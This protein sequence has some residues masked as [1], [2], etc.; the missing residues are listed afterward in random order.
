M[1]A[2]AV[3]ALSGLAAGA[4]ALLLPKKAGATSSPPGTGVPAPPG[5]EPPSTSPP[6]TAT[7]DRV[8][9]LQSPYVSG[10]DVAEL[11][12]RLSAWGFE[13]GTIDGVFGPKTDA[14]VRS[15]QRVA[16]LDADGI[17]GPLTW[18]A[19][20]SEPPPVDSGV[21]G[22]P[23][24]P[25]A[26][27]PAP[28]PSPVPQPVP[29]ESLPPSPGTPPFVPPELF[30]P[31]IAPG[32]PIPGLPGVSV[33]LPSIPGVPVPSQV[34]DSV[35]Q[36]AANALATNDPAAIRA[37]AASIRKQ[38]WP[39]VAAGLEA[40]A[41][42]LATG[43][44][45]PVI[46]Q[47]VVPPGLGTRPPVSAPPTSS[48]PPVP[49]SSGSRILRAQS[50]MMQGGDV[51]EVQ[52][53]LV[54]HGFSPGVQD[55][56]YGP[57]AVAAVQA[58][59]RARGLTVDG[60]VGPQTL[61]ALKAR[62]PM[63]TAAPQPSAPAVAP[64]SVPANARTLGPKSPMLQGSDVLWVQ[65][66]LAAAGFSPGTID[67]VYGPKSV[68]A[69]TAFQ[70]ARGLVADGIVGAKTYTA[71]A[72]VKT[73][74]S[75]DF[76][77]GF[78]FDLTAPPTLEASSPLPGVVPIMAPTSQHTP[79][80]QA[81]VR[82]VQDLIMHPRTGSENR[83]LVLAFQRQI[84]GLNQTGMYGPGTALAL[85]NARTGLVPPAPRYLPR[86]WRKAERAAYRA[87]L[88]AQASHDP[89]RAEEWRQAAR[90]VPN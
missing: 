72:A 60:Q 27:M 65:Q 24:A 14:A 62:P 54:A 39:D 8:L 19:L 70:K 21:Y 73:A 25:N 85:I 23:E 17:V 83:E 57:K 50:P 33:P 36:A 37:A 42:G 63:Q 81:A 55:G 43:V 9:S 51:L 80:Q 66:R 16:G 29:V 46:P 4:V 20:R 47:I 84:I 77:S 15:F 90:D 68:A 34:P 26:G 61:S 30:T 89:Q 52:R 45:P 38:G 49:A 2:G 35:L 69:V 3:L 7:G 48:P 40:A 1:K 71:L 58:F 41:T 59:Q 64:S 74:V 28:L 12:Q 82:M 88:E 6:V 56:V 86:N 5:T 18:A 67:G 79:L 32:V 22:P 10:S 78:G 76:V 75:G 13:V 31:P 44:V 53:L 87:V 11:Q